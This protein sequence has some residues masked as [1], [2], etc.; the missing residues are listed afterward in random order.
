MEN[1]PWEELVTHQVSVAT[2]I[3]EERILLAYNDLKLL[4]GR[5]D[6]NLYN[7][8]QAGMQIVEALKR[9]VTT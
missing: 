3:D 7:S 2:P 5:F 6:Q 8:G 1:T 9:Y 4:N